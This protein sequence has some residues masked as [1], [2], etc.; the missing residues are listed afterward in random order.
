[1]L[2]NS[3]HLYI[4]SKYNSIYVRVSIQTEKRNHIF[5]WE[6]NNSFR[7]RMNL[8]CAE[9]DSMNTFP[10]PFTRSKTHL[11]PAPNFLEYGIWCKYWEKRQNM[12]V[13][14]IFFTVLGII[15]PAISKLFKISIL[16]IISKKTLDKKNS[17]RRSITFSKIQ[18]YNKLFKLDF[19]W[20]H[21]PNLELLLKNS[22]SYPRL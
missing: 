8:E 11:D 20:N 15:E 3:L 14:Y 2:L 10:V 19:I 4:Y 13:K 6:L 9:F 1:M 12:H 21:L 22:L 7:I 17:C 5:V 18:V 16:I